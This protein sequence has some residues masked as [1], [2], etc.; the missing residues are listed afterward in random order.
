MLLEEFDVDKYERSLREEGRKEGR[1]EGREEGTDRMARLV[2]VLIQLNRM[3][4]LNRVLTDEEYRKKLFQE[5][6]L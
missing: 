5:F 4:D 3:E 2:Q 1:E 6:A